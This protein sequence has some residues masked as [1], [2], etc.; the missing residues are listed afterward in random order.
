[1]G[2]LIRNKESNGKLA[3]H[4]SLKLLLRT[5]IVV[6]LNPDT[7]DLLQF[8]NPRTLDAAGYCTQGFTGGTRDAYVVQNVG[9]QLINHMLNGTPRWMKAT[10]GT[11]DP[12]YV[13]YQGAYSTSNPYQSTGRLLSEAYAQMYGCHFTIPNQYRGKITRFQVQFVNMGA[14]FAY[15][16]AIDHNPANK[17]IKNADYGWTGGNGFIVPFHYTFNENCYY[18]LSV[19]NTWP[20]DEYDIGQVGGNGDFRGERDLWTLGGGAG[21]VDGRIPTLTNHQTTWFNMRQDIQDT[22]KQR[23]SIWIVPSFHPYSGADYR[24]CSGFGGDG[25]NNY[26]ACASLHDI[27]LRLIIDP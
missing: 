13:W 11:H 26:W 21:S 3:R 19:V 8:G 16:P 27:K 17:N 24:P 20:H 10:G 22:L 6:T 23:N 2:I 18:H 14:T 7:R 25:S 15:G 12:E 4:S 1:M 5:P 9:Y